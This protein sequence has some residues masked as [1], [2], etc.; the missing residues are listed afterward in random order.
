[1]PL[2]S[3]CIPNYNRVDL[4]QRLIEQ[5]IQD[6]CRNNLFD[7][8][9]ICICDDCSIDNPKIAINKLKKMYPK[10]HIFFQQHTVNMGMDWNFLDS[11]LMAHGEYAWIIGNDDLPTEDG[12]REAIKYISDL[13]DADFIVF[14]FDNYSED[15]K[16]F[17]TIFPLSDESKNQIFLT[18]RQRDIDLL[19]EQTVH[20]CSLFDFLSN[21]IFKRNRW[22]EH[23]DMFIDKM[24]SIFIQVYMNMQTLIEGAKYCY[25]PQKLII[26][27]GDEETNSKIDRMYKIFKGL[28]EVT[29]YFFEGDR[30][31]LVLKKWVDTFCTRE[32]FDDNV[33]KEIKAYMSTVSTPMS[34]VMRKYYVSVNN[35][36]KILVDR[37]IYI[38]GAGKRGRILHKELLN[39]RINVVAFIDKDQEKQIK[40]VDGC[41]VISLGRFIT[42]SNQSDYIIISV[43]SNDDVCGL[44]DFFQ[45]NGLE[46]KILLM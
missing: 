1:M 32:L 23:G 8:V 21:V 13:E 29:N 25:I 38:Y 42:I 4:L 46:E 20:N 6:I 5:C 26:Q 11:V 31:K 39:Q 18:Y 28:Y 33:E 30:K 22:I 14:P 24:N 3:I 2:L 27:Y 19:L 17:K 7:S 10:V 34:D 35:R 43:I 36:K 9:E 16:T 45:E 37:K 15:G 12:I 41:E 40:G 44:I